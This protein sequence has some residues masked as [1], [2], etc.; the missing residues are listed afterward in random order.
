MKI[1]LIG[2]ILTLTLLTAC[3]PKL[4]SIESAAQ[5]VKITSL[6]LAVLEDI[7][8]ELHHAGTLTR[9]TAEIIM[10]FSFHANTVGLEASKF[11]ATLEGISPADERRLER[12]IEPLLDSL[13]TLMAEKIINIPHPGTRE[14]ITTALFMVRL[15]IT[16]MGDF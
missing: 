6:S 2:L 1:K 10:D 3:G 5:G 9:S 12:I 13:D 15:A 4:V 16:S 14:R 8:I 11:I 7:A